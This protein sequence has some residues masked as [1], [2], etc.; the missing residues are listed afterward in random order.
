MIFGGNECWNFSLDGP[1][2]IFRK[3]RENLT[4]CQR[5]YVTNIV[6]SNE[7]INGNEENPMIKDLNQKDYLVLTSFFNLKRYFSILDIMREMSIKNGQMQNYTCILSK[8]Y[9]Y[10]FCVSNI[11]VILLMLKALILLWSTNKDTA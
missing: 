10:T 8:N 3:Q 4:F 6:L 2:K 5:C 7:S 9:G 1:A 11:E